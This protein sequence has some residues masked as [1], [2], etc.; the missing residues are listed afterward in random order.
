MQHI[1]GIFR[2]QIR[3]SSL[4]DTIS[5][6]NQVR[7]IDVFVELIEISKLDFAMKALKTKGRPSSIV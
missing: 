5:P 7:F 6:D 2:Q 1:T 3:F 4:E